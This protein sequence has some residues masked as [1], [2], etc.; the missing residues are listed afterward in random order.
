VARNEQ[1]TYKLSPTLS[2]T[3]RL[4]VRIQELESLLK[5]AQASSLGN[6]LIQLGANNDAEPAGE[7]DG[8][9]VESTYQNSTSLLQSTVESSA[10]TSALASS[11][12]A[13]ETRKQRLIQNAWRQRSL[14]ILSETPEPFSYMLANHWSW[15]QPL[16]NFIYRPAFTRDM[17]VLGPYYSHTLLN[18]MLA[19]STRW[20][21]Q[22]PA[23]RLLLQPYDDGKLFSRHAR[24]LLFEELREG[25]GSI[26]QVQALLMLSAQEC[27][28]GNRTQAWLYSGMA[29][30]LIEDLGI[31]TAHGTYVA[32]DSD[33][34]EDMHLEIRNRL[35]WSC[36]FWDKMISLY[37]GRSP[38]L[39]HKI[40]SP[41]QVILDDSAEDE[42]WVPHG[43]T[44]PPGS[45]YP[46]TKSRAISSF[47]QICNLSVILN[48]ILLDLYD[49]RQ[50]STGAQRRKC[51]TE[52]GAAL[53]MWWSNLP[54]FLK[55]ETTALPNFAPPSHIV[56]LNCLFHTFNI[57]LYRPMLFESIPGPYGFGEDAR[58]LK[59][60][61]TS[62]NSIIALYDLFCRTFGDRRVILALAYSVYTAASIFLL[63]VQA[64][65]GLNEQATGRAMFC[66]EALQRI[67]ASTPV[68]KEAINLLTQKL[69]A[70]G[71][72]APLEAIT[73]YASHADSTQFVEEQQDATRTT[74]H[75]APASEIRVPGLPDFDLCD[76][77]IEPDVFDAFARLEP[78]GVNVGSLEALP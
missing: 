62:A 56:T 59:E 21:R 38:S 17:P 61:I 54:S 73:S 46:E 12:D 19:H 30:R 23:L 33:D 8:T 25:G 58:H 70:T 78:I 22:E 71:A 34:H 44:F 42:I 49:P 64:A 47:M 16:F 66:I 13:I 37:F 4:E 26:T 45:E 1:C 6:S 31:C 57:L 5:H 69:I 55:I 7:G 2:Y 65:D 28:A 11:P 51:V 50:H 67:K 48:Q 39:Q 20:C 29:F 32:T 40:N 68:L 15:I 27:G 60:C 63:Q 9:G 52:Q 14:E 3:R 77:H 35:F 43:V 24:T 10:F 75:V 76:L 53:S 41:P 18:A 72:G 36:Y 74:S